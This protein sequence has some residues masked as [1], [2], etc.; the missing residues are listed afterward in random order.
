MTIP[1]WVGKES[2]I[3]RKL[4]NITE[5]QLMKDPIGYLV[6]AYFSIREFAINSVTL[7]DDDQLSFV[8]PLVNIKRELVKRD[9]D[10]MNGINFLHTKTFPWFYNIVGGFLSHF[11]LLGGASSITGGESV[12][13]FDIRERIGSFTEGW[14][15]IAPAFGIAITSSGIPETSA[16]TTRGPSFNIW[17]LRK[18]YLP[19]ILLVGGGDLT[20]ANLQGVGDTQ[21]L[22]GMKDEIQGSW[23]F[24]NP[25]LVDLSNTINPPESQEDSQVD[26]QVDSQE[27]SQVDSQGTQQNT[28]VEPSGP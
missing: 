12:L 14:P 1:D 10:G 13:D 8:T 18:Y 25:S 6:C 26:S 4:S 3:R 2:L 15:G 22:S 7:E 17:Y 9:I 28:Q 20:I 23:P 27:D 5:E 21:L 19:E 11:F 24:T 16:T